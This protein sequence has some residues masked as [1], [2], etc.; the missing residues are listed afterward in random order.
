MMIAIGRATKTIIAHVRNDQQGSRQQGG[1]PLVVFTKQIVQYGTGQYQ[2]NDSNQSKRQH[3]PVL[4]TATADTESQHRRRYDQPKQGFMK[5]FITQ[6]SR[7][8]GRACRQQ[9]R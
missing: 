1:D 3:Q 8:Q 6:K 5:C 7:R 9:N 4:V 2:P